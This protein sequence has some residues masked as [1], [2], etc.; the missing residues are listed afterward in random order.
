VCDLTK[1]PLEAN[2]PAGEVDIVTM[3]FVLSAIPPEA[4]V[5]AL[6]NVAGLLRPGGVVIF[7]DYGQYDMAQLRFGAGHRLEDGLYVRQD[8]TLAYYFDKGGPLYWLLS[9]SF[10]MQ[11]SSMTGQRSLVVGRMSCREA[12][13]DGARSWPGSHGKR[14]RGAADGEPE[15]ADYAEPNLCPGALPA[16]CRRMTRRAIRIHACICTATH[17]TYVHSTSIRLR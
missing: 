12:G 6:R 17:I 9:F 13:R 5:R 16:S 2:V 7:R 3:I 4:M 11:Y 1:D 10:E 15:T 8:G 14:L